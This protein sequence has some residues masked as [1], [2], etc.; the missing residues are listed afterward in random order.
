MPGILAWEF[1][2]IKVAID[3]MGGDESPE[4]I[5]K[6]AVESLGETE[7]TKLFLFGPKERISALL[8]Q[9]SFDRER[10]ELVNAEDVISL[11]ESPVLAIR[12]KKDSSIVKGMQFVKEGK[13]DALISAGSSGAIL[14]GAQLIVGRI[15]GIYRPPLAALIPTRRGVCLLTDCGANV[16]ASPEWLLQFAKMG[17][18]YLREMLGIERPSV[19]LVNIGA[20][21][22]KGNRLVKEAMP[23]LRADEELN[24]QGSV[25]A[26][27]IVEGSCDVVV[28][29][30]FVG[31]VVLKMY[32]GVGKMLLTEIKDCLRQSGPITL[33]GAALI[34]KSL[35]KGL[36]KFDAKR[37][38]GAPILGLKGLVVKVHGN[39]DGTELKHAVRQ[40]A[41]FCRRDI[42]GKIERSLLAEKS[43]EALPDQEE[44]KG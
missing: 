40:C 1:F 20:E 10:V 17:S 2:M 32:E 11:H 7:D 33:L 14:A 29:D 19:G 13:A 34:R 44:E 3:A 38:G 36:S 22:E 31:N 21:E 42:V 26:R 39:T 37:Y 9:Y 41:D 27:D 8:S 5:V 30:A 43:E 24:F 25:E 4:A 15:R 6:G 35:K 23:L 18:I 12:R 28:A 16:D